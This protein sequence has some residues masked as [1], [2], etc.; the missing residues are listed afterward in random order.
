MAHSDIWHPA[1]WKGLLKTCLHD[2]LIYNAGREPVR[3]DVRDRLFRYL[4][5]KDKEVL[6]MLLEEFDA[7]KYERTI[8][9]EGR[10]EGWKE[11]KEEGT[12]EVN[13][14]GILMKKAGRSNEFL[15]SLSNRKLQRK[16][17]IEFGLEKA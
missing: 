17:L 12:E 9:A 7:E 10:E 4:F 16:L 3:R 15:K 8:R 14:L 6:G 2:L 1:T 5:G 13:T 11:G